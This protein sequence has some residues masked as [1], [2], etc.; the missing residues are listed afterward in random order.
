ML[1]AFID[2]SG[3][4]GFAQASSCWLILGA[5]VI[6]ESDMNPVKAKLTH[7]VSQ[8]WRTSPPAHVHFVDCP[9]PKRKALL[10]LVK[11]IDLTCMFVAAHKGSLKPDEVQRLTCPSLYCYIAKH[12]VERI[13]WYARDRNE[14]VRITFA[15]RSQIAFSKLKSYFY[16]VLRHRSFPVHDI[17]FSC[18]D[19]MGSIPANQNSL[20]QAADWMTGAVAAGLNPDT[21]GN[22]ELSYAELLWGKYWIRQ[23][24]FWSYGLKTIP[25]IEHNE[26]LFSRI[27]TWLEDPTTLG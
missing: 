17:A 24:K 22:V 19:S 1:H 20:L 4:D 5:Y 9:H 25:R 2:E 12:L 11:S 16:D 26:K 27:N 18:I 13:S 3:D 7:G 6:R 10:N 8:I 15:Q 14:S 21:Y 23:G